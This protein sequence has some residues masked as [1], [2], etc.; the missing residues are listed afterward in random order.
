[1]LQRLPEW[2]H[3]FLL[4]PTPRHLQLEGWRGRNANGFIIMT[5]VASPTGLVSGSVCCIDVDD[6]EEAYT[7][8]IS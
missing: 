7:D 1:M 8:R 2:L 4:Q 5:S 6:V 3:D